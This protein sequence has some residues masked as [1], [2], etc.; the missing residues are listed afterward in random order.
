MTTSSFGLKS[1]SGK[2][3]QAG[4][5]FKPT[6]MRLE[7]LE[8]REVCAANVLQSVALAPMAEVRQAAQSTPM[9]VD[10]TH[11]AAA[12]NKAAST[13]SLVGTTNV[14]TIENRSNLN[15]SISIRWSPTSAWQTY[16]LTPNTFRRFWHPS[17]TNA[18]V[19]F[20]YSVKS[21]YQAKQY[22]LTTRSE[23]E[24]PA[25]PVGKGQRYA[26]HN[27]TYSGYRGVEL[28]RI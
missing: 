21:G 13:R 7:S 15:V 5:E 17:D 19:R 16:T 3:S 2:S 10:Y 6:Q 27:A 25:G 9:Q 14:F 24:G 20:D 4:R 23:I 18:E 11:P 22:S 26:F 8:V 28:F 12:S 1:V